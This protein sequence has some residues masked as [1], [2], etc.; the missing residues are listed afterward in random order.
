MKAA[1]ALCARQATCSHACEPRILWLRDEATRSNWSRSPNK[2]PSI[3]VK[4]LVFTCSA[5]YLYV[6]D[7]CLWCQYFW[8]SIGRE[9][10]APHTLGWSGF[11][12]AHAWGWTDTRRGCAASKDPRPWRD[13]GC[14]QPRVP[15]KPSQCHHHINGSD[16]WLLIRAHL[17]LD[18]TQEVIDLVVFHSH[19]YLL[20]LIEIFLVYRGSEGNPN[21]ITDV[22]QSQRTKA[23]ACGPSASPAHFIKHPQTLMPL[24]W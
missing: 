23:G 3:P 6:R 16:N 13:W 2:C 7:V 15:G 5:C 11:L 24:W 1:G 14:H 18:V 19:N 10:L 17:G 4:G 8:E 21:H 20:K 9:T 22:M 12:S